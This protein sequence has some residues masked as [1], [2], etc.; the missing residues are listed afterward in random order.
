MRTGSWT[1]R[2]LQARRAAA[3]RRW[4]RSARVARER[5]RQ[6]FGRGGSAARAA[7]PN[8]AARIWNCPR[9]SPTRGSRRA[10]A[11]P[12]ASA[13]HSAPPRYLRLAPW[14]ARP[15]RPSRPTAT[16]LH[17]PKDD[18]SPPRAA[19]GRPL[20]CRSRP[21]ECLARSASQLR[22]PTPTT[23]RSS[24]RRSSA[25]RRRRRRTT[26][27]SSASTRRRPPATAWWGG[28]ESFAS[29]APT[30]TRGR[31]PSRSARKRG[32]RRRGRG[33]RQ[34]M[35]GACACRSMPPHPT[36]R[37][38]T[39]AS[40]EAQPHRARALSKRQSRSSARS[41]S[42]AGTMSSVVGFISG[43]FGGGEIEIEGEISDDDDGA[44]TP[45]GDAEAP[46]QTTPF[47]E[48]GRRR[49]AAGPRARAL[50]PR[51][52]Q[53]VKG[54][55]RRLGARDAGA[56]AAAAVVQ[57]ERLAVAVARKAAR[58]GREWR[59]RRLVVWEALRR[60]GGAAPLPLDARALPL[61]RPPAD[62]RRRRRRRVLR[63]AARGPRHLSARARPPRQPL[64]RAI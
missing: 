48:T 58:A 41:L 2:R 55:L 40:D 1:C 44:V 57:K 35:A 5:R 11:V 42:R 22:T 59:R 12:R 34:P 27:A 32:R 21:S 6:Q 64:A 3:Q 31:A 46:R 52:L 56:L 43:L 60:R 8:A 23:P 50:L 18:G 17:V 26:R 38:A 15:R 10:S 20:A 45:R 33:V 25:T 19:A 4:P 14:A 61:R 62:W 29:L 49:A 63:R 53:V 39:R 7:S 37:S 9:P 30:T 16:H 47:S 28:D 13:R 24:R 51:A 36:S 54:R